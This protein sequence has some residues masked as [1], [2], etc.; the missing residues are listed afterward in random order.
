LDLAVQLVEPRGTLVLKS[1]V[2]DSA[3]GSL[4]EL[5]INEV[6]LLGSRCGRFAPAIRILDRG[7]IDPRS[8]I[9]YEYSLQEGELAMETASRQ[10]ILKVIMSMGTSEKQERG[11]SDRVG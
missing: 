8:L 4:N 3:F 5:V 7:F 9:Q 2:A 6:Q 10:G 1:T 11:E